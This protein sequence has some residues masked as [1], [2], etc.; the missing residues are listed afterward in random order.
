MIGKFRFYQRKGIYQVLLHFTSFAIR[1]QKCVKDN[2]PRT[3]WALNCKVTENKRF[4]N[5]LLLDKFKQMESSQ[6]TNFYLETYSLQIL[7]L[8]SSYAIIYAS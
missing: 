2:W 6:E 5:A 1:R 4:Y 7:S 8:I 3:K